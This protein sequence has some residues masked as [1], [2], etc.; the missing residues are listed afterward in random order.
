MKL[1]GT[2]SFSLIV[3]ALMGTFPA[4]H[5]DD[6]VPSAGLTKHQ[7]RQANWRLEKSVRKQ[8]DKS[9]GDSSGILIVAR[10]GAVTLDGEVT[11]EQKIDAAGKAASTVAG[12]SSVKNNL[13]LRIGGH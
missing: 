3:L 5:A 4:V 1:S 10:S 8:I 13:K 6:A 11:D 9:I 2:L 12:V 7:I